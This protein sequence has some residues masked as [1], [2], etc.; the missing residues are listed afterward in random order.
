MLRSLRGSSSS[1]PTSRVLAAKASAV[2]QMLS[3]DVVQNNKS[4]SGP[5]V[6]VS[7]TGSFAYFF[8][9]SLLEFLETVRLCCVYWYSLFLQPPSHLKRPD[10]PIN[11]LPLMSSSLGQFVFVDAVWSSQFADAFL[12]LQSSSVYLTSC[13][14]PRLFFSLYLKNILYFSF[15]CRSAWI[16]TLRL[17]ECVNK[18]Q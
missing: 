17:C 16:L 13:L 8:I 10:K 1:F 5:L 4:V 11:I 18:C 9:L 3:C 12:S 14:G 15:Y 7:N 6:E 2:Q